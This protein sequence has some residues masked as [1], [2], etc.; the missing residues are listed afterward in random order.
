M[1]SVAFLATS[2]PPPAVSW[3][4][5]FLRALNAE[6]V[7]SILLNIPV[8]LLAER[9]TARGRL[10][11][12]NVD[13]DVP[14]CFRSFDEENKDSSSSKQRSNERMVSGSSVSNS[15]K[16]DKRKQRF[17]RQEA[18]VALGRKAV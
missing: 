3:Q 14:Q 4:Q 1:R 2:S 16:N 10:K 17:L 9:I 5:D 6:S 12:C 8:K 13:G 7:T 18:H 15:M 11:H